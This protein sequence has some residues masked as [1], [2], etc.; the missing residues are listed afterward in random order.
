MNMNGKTSRILNGFAGLSLMLM[1]TIAIVAGQTRVSPGAEAAS[2]A[3]PV[4]PQA[5]LALPLQDLRHLEVLGNIAN[6]VLDLPVRIEIDV[7]SGRIT[8]I[9]KSPLAGH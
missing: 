9:V 5:K 6:S 3:A 8:A 7:D 1:F 2:L 4:Y